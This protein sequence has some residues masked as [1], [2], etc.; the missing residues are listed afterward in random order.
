LFSSIAKL[1]IPSPDYY[2]PCWFH[3]FQSI[4]SFIPCSLVGA[5]C[6]LLFGNLCLSCLARG[7][8][9]GDR[10]LILLPEGIIVCEY[11]RNARKR[12]IKSFE[13][14]DL[15]EVTLK[16]GRGDISFRLSPGKSEKESLCLSNYTARG[17]NKKGEGV[18]DVALVGLSGPERTMFVK[19]NGA[20][21]LEV[22]AL[23]TEA[24]IMLLPRCSSMTLTE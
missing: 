23:S 3:S 5:P 10:V 21:S 6:S 2:C 14:A 20:L 24:M 7:E 11:W 13:Y 18:R 19:R 9:K 4:A 15:D 22:Q 12:R 8:N 1:T 16:V 17:R